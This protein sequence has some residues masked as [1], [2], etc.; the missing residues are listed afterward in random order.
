MESQVGLEVVGNV[1]DESLEWKFSNE[2][3]GRFLI[4]SD[5]SKGNS[6]WSESVCSLDTTWGLGGLGL[7]GHGLLWGLSCGGFSCGM[8]GSCHFVCL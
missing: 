8:L 2:E 7:G 1:S 4:L 5:V 6:S 3:L